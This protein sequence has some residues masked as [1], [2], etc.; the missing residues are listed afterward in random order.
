MFESRTSHAYGSRRLTV[1]Y[2]GVCMLLTCALCKVAIGYCEPDDVAQISTPITSLR[3]VCLKC[4][5]REAMKDAD[6]VLLLPSVL[7][8]KG[9]F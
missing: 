7:R 3:C 9:A 8:A 4:A 5:N 6:A 1:L 2:K